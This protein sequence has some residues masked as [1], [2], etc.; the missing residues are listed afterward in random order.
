MSKFLSLGLIL[1]LASGCA[2]V[3]DG[4]KT[5]KGGIIGT[6]AGAAVGAIW[7]NA[8]GNAA[9]G[10]IIGALAGGAIGGVTG[11][12]MDKQEE[13]LRKAGIA[14]QRDSQGN[15]VIKMSGES[16]KF[17]TNQTS[18]KPEG[19]AM[20]DKIAEVI[21]KYPENRI[22]IEGHTDNVGK[23]TYNVTLSQGRADSV[24]AYLI[25]KGLPP[26]CVVGT[27]GYGESRPVADNAT[28]E[29]RAQNRRVELKIG[30]DKDEAEKNEKDRELY[31]NSKKQ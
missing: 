27:I 11:A 14:T 8:R 30:M 22:G 25:S 18:L 31:K 16:L 5:E 10:A 9:E 20:L 28:A 13:K 21:S 12:V 7:G 6:V 2:T 23:D 26:R 17:D 29:G 1:A 4:D 3:G 19:K 15:L 24:Q